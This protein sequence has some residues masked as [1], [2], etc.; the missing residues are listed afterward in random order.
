MET[1]TA[2]IDTYI[3]KSTAQSSTLPDTEKKL[4]LAGQTITIVQADSAADGHLKVTLSRGGGVWFIFEA[5]WSGV[6]GSG[7]GSAS[8][9][10]PPQAVSLVVS[11]EGF[12]DIVY[13]DGVG[14]P[15]IGYGTTRYPD[16]RPVRFGDPAVDKATARHYLAHDLEATK[17]ALV[18]TIPD[19]TGMTDNQRSA[20][21]SFAFNLGDFFL[22][23]P[24]FRTISAALQAHRWSDVPQVLPLYSD[25]G[26]PN[27]HAGLLRRRLAEAQLWNGEGPFA[28]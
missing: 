4:F 15:T 8:A 12:S 6:V 1:L 22:G 2:K 3:K 18:G 26:D 27:V 23:N 25:P 24:G 11:F 20:L 10:V 13:N 21:I 16:G 17:N 5:H 28:A 7:D 14:V 19:W 9:D